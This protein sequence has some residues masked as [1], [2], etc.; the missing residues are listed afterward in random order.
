MDKTINNYLSS[1]RKQRFSLYSIVLVAVYLLPIFAQGRWERIESPTNNFLRRITLSDTNTLW[2]SGHNGTIIKSTD[3]GN[4]WSVLPTNTNNIIMNHS[5][6]NNQLVFAII[7]EF[8]NPPYGTYLIKS[9]NG[10]MNWQSQF[11]PIQYE[12]LQSIH[13]FNENTGI[14]AGSRTYITTNGGLTWTQAQRDS[15]LVANLPFLNIKMLSNNYGYACGGFI[16]VAGVI[17]KTTNGGLSWKTNGIS[18]DEIFDMVVLDSLNIVALAGDPEFIYNLAFV[19]STDGGENWTYTELPLYAVSLGIDARDF[20]NIWSAA[21]YKFIYTTNGGNNWQEKPTPDSTS[22]YDLVFIN[23]QLGFAC[24]ENGALLKY[25]E[26]GSNVKSEEIIANDFILYQN[27][28]NPFG[29]NSITNNTSTKISWQCSVSSHQ[30]LKIYDILGNEIA[31]LVDEYREAGKYEIE[32]PNIET[33]P[34]LSLP[35][36]VYFYQLKVGNKM[37]TKKMLIIK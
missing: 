9:T 33:W 4:S 2:A 34:A 12:Y 1:F 31:T 35:S 15:D 3:Q 24:G 11:F 13:F 36:G 17:W 6:V 8:E 27:Y 23:N 28:P 19:K 26:N 22:I 18:P 7:W 32:F 37:D 14:V 5:A 29:T 16:D 21:G 25:I 20:N 30:T 10:G